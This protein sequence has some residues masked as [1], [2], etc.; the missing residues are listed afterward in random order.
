MSLPTFF[1][2]NVSDNLKPFRTF[3]IIIASVCITIPIFLRIA[4]PCTHG[5][6]CSISDYAYMD[7]SYI[8]GMLLCI[9]AMLFIF[10]GAVYFYKHQSF[11]MMTPGK[12]YNVVLGVSLLMVILLPYKE[13][14]YPHY[15]FASIFFGFNA[16]VIGFFHQRK[17]RVIS[18][19]LAVAT[20][21]S[22]G[23]HF[24]FKKEISLFWG[25]WLSL[26]VIGVHFI[27]MADGI[28]SLDL[29]ER[30][31]NENK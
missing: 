21:T 4:D 18:R 2:S 8:F 27:L 31:A 7:R 16:F 6:R 30:E 13:F 22:L 23:L 20:L 3:E 25:E 10:N 29:E 24:A 19:I 11:E 9:A 14:K 1:S 28:I 12:W 15:T 5:F 17:Y 26:I